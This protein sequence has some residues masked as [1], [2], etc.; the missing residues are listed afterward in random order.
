MRK[1]N[2]LKAKVNSMANMSYCKF[3]NTLDDLEECRGEMTHCDSI[4][5][6]DLSE[7]E[8]SALHQMVECCSEIVE[9]YENMIKLK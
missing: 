8:L 5:D 3:E 4:E 2:I 1:Q 9:M 7:N 6:M